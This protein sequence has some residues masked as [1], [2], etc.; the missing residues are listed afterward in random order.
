[1]FINKYLYFCPAIKT[2]SMEIK[3]GTKQILNLLNILSW[4]IFVGL[5]IET[6][7]ILFNS[8]YAWYKPEVARYF[9][10]GADLSELYAFDRGHFITQVILMIIVAVMKTLIF[11]LIVKLFYDKK[12]NIARPFDPDVTKLVF[13][14][15]YLCFG[16]GIFSH[17]GTRYAAWIE[18]QGVNMPDIHYLRIGGADVWLFM[19]V[20]L[21]VIG[22]VFKKGTELQTESDLTV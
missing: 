9:W 12:F 15:A 13:N 6:G 11:Y 14:I 3:I 2:N 17:W 4:I 18:E 22:L 19:A 10:N 21:I 16:A 8:V 5:C 1:L 20:V 7:G